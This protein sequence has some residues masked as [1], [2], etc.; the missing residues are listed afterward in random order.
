MAS[1]DL[2]LELQRDG[3]VRKKIG[4]QNARGFDY[5]VQN[6]ADIFAYPHSP[7][8]DS[9]DTIMVM[10]TMGDQSIIVAYQIDEEGI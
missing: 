9:S 1:T 8:W 5:S 2:I 7:A 10:S 3:I 4:G 6:P